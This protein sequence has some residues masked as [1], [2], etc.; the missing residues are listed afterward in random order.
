MGKT[1]TG[2]IIPFGVAGFI[3]ASSF[4]SSGCGG[5]RYAWTQEQISEAGMLR[6]E[7]KRTGQYDEIMKAFSNIGEFYIYLRKELDEKQAAGEIEN[8]V[9]VIEYYRMKQRTGAKS[10]ISS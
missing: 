6:S 8:N 5:T 1:L 7:S 10:K 4:L 2:K 9:T 3:A